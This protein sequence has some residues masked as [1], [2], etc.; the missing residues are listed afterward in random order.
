[1]FSLQ[2]KRTVALVFLMACGTVSD[3]LHE[4]ADEGVTWWGDVQPIVEGRCTNCHVEGGIGGFALDTYDEAYLWRGPIQLA[5]TNGTMPPWPATGEVQYDYDWSLTD[6]QVNTIVSWGEEGAP[7]GNE[8]LAGASLPAISSSLS[9]V[10]LTL[11]MSGSY[12]P[13]RNLDDD[14][15]CFPMAWP[16]TETRYITGFNALPGNHGVV[17]H[18]A[19]YLVSG[20]NMIGDSIFDQLQDWSEA[21]EEL[22]YTCFGGPSG[23]TGDIQLPIQQV[24]NWVP[25]NRGVDFPSGTGIKVVPGS[26][27]VL[28]L[29]YNIDSFSDDPT[30]QTLIEFKLE[31]TVEKEAAFAP[32]LDIMW[33]LGSM[34][35]PAGEESISYTAEEDPRGFFN[36]LNPELVFEEGFLI[37]SVML[38]MHELGVSGA[39]DLV[40]SDGSVTPLLGIPDWDF[41]WQMT[42]RLSEPIIFQVGDKLSVNC[43]YDNSGAEAVNTY[44]GEG[45]DDEMC[46]ANL[47]VTQP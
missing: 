28:Q 10:D 14:Y 3:P 19:A 7:L 13:N 33:T 40:H 23:P 20:D 44:W 32:W 8:A 34:N 36:F 22:G 45:T 12:T 9:R 18:I 11:S 17:H 42:Y 16:E 4:V 24:G 21:E 2:H 29:H 35:I 6:E 47:Y 46:V 27:I 1:V 31:D 37:H 5:V 39:V 38:H 30:D 15:R 43:T 41:E 26:W 25:G